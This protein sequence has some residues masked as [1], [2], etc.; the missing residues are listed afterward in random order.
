MHRGYHSFAE[1]PGIL[2]VF[3]LTGVLLLPRAALPLNVFEPRYLELVDD[4]LKGNRLIGMIQPTESEESVLKPKLSNVG[5][6][7]RII[8]WRETEDNRYLIT[9]A[10]LCRFRVKE[11]I[12]VLS[13]FRQ[14]ACDFAPFAGDLAQSDADGNFPR[15]RLLQALKDYLFRRDMKADWKSVMTAPA[16]SLVNALAMMCPFEPAEKQA[17]LEAPGWSE[18]VSTLVALLEISTAGQ[19]PGSLN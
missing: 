19:G 4:A 5:C 3:P 8:S 16:E 9:L 11:E 10:G 14:V 6:A 13:A 1:L 15:E 18:R 2:P 12:S 17:L 7:G